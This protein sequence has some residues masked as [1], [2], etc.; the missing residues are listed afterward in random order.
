MPMMASLVKRTAAPKKGPAA[1]RR[2]RVVCISDTHELHRELRLPDG[3]LLIH[4]GDFTVFNSI[5]K[6]R[7]FNLWLGELPHRH[8]VVIPGNHDGAFHKDPQFRAEITNAV[9][10]I[11]EGVT[12]CGLNVWG[13]PV[14]CDDAAYGYTT[15][16]ERA[17][18]YPSI[19]K[20]T[21]ILITHGPPYGIL[22][23]KPGSH[24][25]QGCT[26]LRIAV[27][28]LQPRLHVYGHVHAGYGTCATEKIGLPVP[29]QISDCLAE[30]GVRLRPAFG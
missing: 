12:A 28:Q 21:H 22:D 26:E 29:K 15:R 23:R 2:V 13:S 7:D 30:P 17:R 4:A 24:I 14:T 19:P 11:N 5:A 20:D 16:E 25:R 1:P 27:S 6:V 10:L 18:L 3:D 8:K 9:L